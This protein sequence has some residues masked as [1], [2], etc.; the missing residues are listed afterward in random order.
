MSKLAGRPFFKMN[1][2]GNEI[3]VLDLRGTAL[4]VSPAEARAIHRS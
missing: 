4:A 1:G 2:L 3:I